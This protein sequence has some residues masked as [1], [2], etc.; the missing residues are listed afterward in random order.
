MEMLT[1]R[2]KREIIVRFSGKSAQMEKRHLCAS[3]GLAAM[4]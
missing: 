1:A 4:P 2:A 3:S